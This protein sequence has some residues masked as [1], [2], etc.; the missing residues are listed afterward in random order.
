ME[1]H[2]ASKVIQIAE[3]E[4]G[5]M[6]K[7]AAAYRTNKTILDSK[8][9]G[10]GK[11][12]Y[13]KYGRDMK[14]LYPAVIDFP[15]PWCDCFVDWCFQKA[16]GV[17]NAKKLLAGHFD[18]YTV[19][20]AG[21]YKNKNA[22][23]TKNPKV[24][25][26]IFFKN[27][28]GGINHTGLVYKVTATT[29]YT[30]EGNTSSASG[31]VPNGGTVAKKS[32]PLNYPRIAG[33]GR[34]R[35]DTEEKTAS[36]PAKSPSNKAANPKT[37]KQKKPAPQTAPKPVKP[38]AKKSSNSTYIVKKGDTLSGIGAKLKIDWKKIA[39]I[40]GIK[41]PYKLTIGQT[42]KLPD[43]KSSRA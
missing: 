19:N 27:T 13:T 16:Y 26:Q 37:E 3:A 18:D 25:D 24:G 33:Y 39:D 38:V 10:A 17:S 5:Y 8:T 29:V 15:A 7:S 12:N 42:L 31:V 28:N 41:Q 6:E 11:D 43:G 20:S 40:N 30:I 9:A 23:H 1:K 22:W 35:Y 14:K 4:V 2:Y 34:P 36:K 32:Y 21:L